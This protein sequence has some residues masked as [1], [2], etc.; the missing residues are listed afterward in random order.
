MQTIGVLRRRNLERHLMKILIAADGSDYSQEAIQLVNQLDFPSGSS[1]VVLNVL[2]DF[3]A[4]SYGEN[5]REGVH[6][7]LRDRRQ[8]D[9]DTVINDVHANLKQN[10]FSLRTEVRE[11]HVADQVNQL[12]ADERA[13]LIVVG[14][15]GLSR[16]DRFLLGSTSETLL[17]HAP[18][19]VLMSRPGSP[20]KAPTSSPSDR[21]RIQLCWDSSPQCRQALQT[22][23][24]LPISTQVE[25]QIVAVLPIS[26]AYRMDI[27]QELSA[28]WQATQ[29][30]AVSE[31]ESAA[32]QLKEAGFDLVT[33]AVRDGED[34][35]ETLLSMAENWNTDIIML[36]ASGKSA[37][38][39]FLIGSVA[40]KVMR[41]APCAVWLERQP[42]KNEVSSESTQP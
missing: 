11:G 5:I 27:L 32:E 10:G 37:I 24:N 40:S 28:Q 21:L 42:A 9:A 31:V 33:T 23:V 12:A 29:Q 20:P 26:K 15:R 13:D 3:K 8:Q 25:V 1:F 39:R 30:A 7:S 14:S 16:L 38:D 34:I 35:A 4:F 19:S 36:G 22:L 2:E 17:K 18:C 6:Q 41:H